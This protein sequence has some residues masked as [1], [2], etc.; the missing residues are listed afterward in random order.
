M[1][2]EFNFIKIGTISYIWHR[3]D[4]KIGG[5]IIVKQ[6]IASVLFDILSYTIGNIILDIKLLRIEKHFSISFEF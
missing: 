4:R 2:F 5:K 6:I 3:N 1:N